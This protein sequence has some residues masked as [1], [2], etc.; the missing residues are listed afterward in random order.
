MYLIYLHVLY[1]IGWCI[2]GY[3]GLEWI[4]DIFLPAGFATVGQ[5]MRGTEESEGLFSIFHS[6]ANDSED[7][8]NWIVQQPWSNGEI[9]S[10]GAS[11]DGLGAFTMTTNQPTW[12]SKLLFFSFFC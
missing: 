6:D 3:L 8:G 7:L 4:P 9:Y 12:V 11:A 2:V 1:C 5:D 10:F